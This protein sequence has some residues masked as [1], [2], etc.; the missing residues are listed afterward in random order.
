MD[1]ALAKFVEWLRVKGYA[2]RSAQGF[3]DYVRDF[4]AFLSTQGIADVRGI[5]PQAVYAYQQFLFEKVNARNGQRLQVTTR[6]TYLA[7]LKIF[8]RCMKETG[9]LFDDP[10]ADI[11]QSKPPKRLPSAIP[12][13]SE[14]K[15][16]LN[17]PD[18]TTAIGFRN[19]CILELLYTSGIRVTE[20][21]N[22][23]LT[24]VNFEDG[25]VQINAGKGNKDRVVPM[26]KICSRYLSHYVAEVRP[27]LDTQGGTDALFLTLGGRPF[28]GRKMIETMVEDTNRLA[29]I[30]KRVTP[31]SFRH[32]MA[33]HM[34]MHRAPIRVIQ[35]ILGHESLESTQIYTRVTIM[36][37]KA[38]HARCHPRNHDHL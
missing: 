2:A 12:T 3:P 22:L 8:F 23:K 15:R 38:C 17:A 16:I 1:E 5:T 30:Q 24:D 14:I 9:L 32:A 6:N 18:T 33:T 34:M 4:I 7:V 31:H 20:L 19:R 37:L 35:E 27:L 26:G 10:T 29:G 25:I 13:N 36:D 11:R 28:A 21:V